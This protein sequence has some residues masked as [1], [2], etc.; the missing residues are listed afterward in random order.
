M[1]KNNKKIGLKYLYPKL[2]TDLS[3][4]NNKKIEI[5]KNASTLTYHQEQ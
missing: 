5:N 1:L 3:L 4:K 2:E